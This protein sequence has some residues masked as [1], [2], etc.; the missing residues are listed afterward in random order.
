[1][2]VKRDKEQKTSREATARKSEAAAAAAASRRGLAAGSPAAGASPVKKVDA[3]AG[4]CHGEVYH[5]RCGKSSCP[6]DHDPGRVAAFK[7]KYPDKPPS[8]A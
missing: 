8:R 5:G 2:Q 6:F 7:A 4:P 3:N 1:M